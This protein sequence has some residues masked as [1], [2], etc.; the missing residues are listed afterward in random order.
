M[1]GFNSHFNT[2]AAQSAVSVVTGF[3]ALLLASTA[4]VAA[5]AIRTTDSN[6]VPQCVTPDRLM[7]FLRDRNPS[8]DPRYRDIA[9][10]YKQY[11]DAWHVRWDYAFYQMILETNA[12]SYRRGN[13][14]RGDVHE[15][16]NNFA[17]IGA[18]GHG[19]PGERFPD[20]KTRSVFR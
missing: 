9:V 18:T 20:V 19:A 2:G 15:K 6:H 12:L 10:L 17:G 16:Q 3:A 1:S 13:G 14:R 7:A 4:L 8:V 11:G 5:P